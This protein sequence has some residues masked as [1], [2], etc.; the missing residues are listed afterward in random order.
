M[1]WQQLREATAQYF[2]FGKLV[3]GFGPE[4]I[5][6][7]LS[8]SP[9]IK[10]LYIG[11]IDWTWGSGAEIDAK[12]GVVSAA[13]INRC[14]QVEGLLQEA[15]VLIERSLHLDRSRAPG[16]PSNADVRRPINLS[17]NRCADSKPNRE[18]NR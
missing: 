8:P 10:E 15:A 11:P 12:L 7:L 17:E 14:N 1:D 2:C 3:R 13:Y 6:N 9:N 4:E 18:I 5:Q 16:R